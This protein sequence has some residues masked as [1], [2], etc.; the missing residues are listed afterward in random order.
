MWLKQCHV[1]HPWLGMVYTTDKMVMTGGWFIIVLSTLYHCSC[2]FFR[3]LRAKSN[4]YSLF[5]MGYPKVLWFTMIFP[6]KMAMVIG[7]QIPVVS[8]CCGWFFPSKKRFIRPSQYIYIY[9]KLIEQIHGKNSLTMS[10]FSIIVHISASWNLNRIQPLFLCR[11]VG[12]F[13]PFRFFSIHSMFV[14]IFIQDG[15]LQL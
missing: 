7:G 14:Y 12:V 8:G 6:F 5:D 1:C 3:H 15:A 13:P 2:V 10:M 11:A 9:K 4:L